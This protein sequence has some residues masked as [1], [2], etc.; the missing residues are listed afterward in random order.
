LLCGWLVA[1][2]AYAQA[3][4]LQEIKKRGQIRVAF[5]NEFPPFSD[6]GKGI[7]I[8][9]AQALA[10]KL[11]VKMV[12]LPFDADENVEDDL[13]N[14]V[15]KGHYL[16]YGPADMMMHVPVDREYMAKVEQVRFFA[17]YYRERF[18][19]ARSLA[20]IPDLESMSAFEKER[21]GVEGAS[22]PHTMLLSLDAGK[23]RNN[24]IHFKN[25]GAA[26]AALKGGEIAAV[27]AQQSELEGA[28]N[29][30]GGFAISEPPIPVLNRRQWALGV[31]VKSGHEELARALQQA[32]NE[33]VAEGAVSRI[34]GKHGVRYRAP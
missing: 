3:Y 10:A 12:P 22:L 30:A 21:I 15:W 32:M 17:P 19:I 25:A 4:D 34:F 6:A 9:L 31:A 23:Y 11:G 5:Y 29:G 14:M 20:R 13:R 33:L 1:W 2:A 8:E 16:G 18:S 7:D 27:L 26:I 28:L 24:V